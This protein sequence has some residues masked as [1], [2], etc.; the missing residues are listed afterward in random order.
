M[1][2]LLRGNVNA[3]IS[4]LEFLEAMLRLGIKFFG[5]ANLNLTKGKIFHYPLCFQ[6]PL[7]SA[8]FRDYISNGG[9]L[10]H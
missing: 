2:L 3:V 6:L 8:N 7:S 9:K 1:K 4:I 10:V 5:A